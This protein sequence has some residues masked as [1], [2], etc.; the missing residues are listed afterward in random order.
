MIKLECIDPCAHITLDLLDFIFRFRSDD[1]RK[2][3]H[4]K[5][6][7]KIPFPIFFSDL[8]LRMDFFF[9][10]NL[11]RKFRVIKANFPSNSSQFYD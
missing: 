4:W 8:G 3:C 9:F 6:L 5:I 11:I 1:F 7:K 2:Y 10:E